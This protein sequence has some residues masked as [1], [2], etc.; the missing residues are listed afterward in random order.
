[1]TEAIEREIF[2]TDVLFIGAGP[3]CLAGAIRLQNL[4]DDYNDDAE[5]N[6]VDTIH[7]KI[8]VLE[9]GNEVGAHGISGAVLDPRALDELFP[10]WKEDETFP[11]ERFV[12]R[13]CMLMLT[14]NSGFTIPVLPP[15]FH[16][17]GKPI[18][19]AIAIVIEG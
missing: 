8:T 6:G 1:M 9:K 4:V 19:G 7:P 11:V 15:E 2:E 13:E 18:I 16:D 3:A 10:G 14:E 12:E 5:A 17:K